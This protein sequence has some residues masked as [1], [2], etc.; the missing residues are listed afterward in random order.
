[1]MIRGTFADIQLRNQL[2][3]GVEVPAASAAYF[4]H[5]AILQ[6]GLRQLLVIEDPPARAGDP[7]AV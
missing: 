7:A 4:R 2:V 6:C 3:P 1:V 5:G